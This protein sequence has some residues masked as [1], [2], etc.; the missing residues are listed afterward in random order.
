MAAEPTVSPLMQFPIVPYALIILVFYFLVFKP[1]KDKQKQ[2]KKM[3]ADLKKNDQVV[4]SGGLF[5][6]VVNVRPESITLR[7][8]ENVRVEVESAAIAR[9][10]KPKGQAGE[11]VSAERRG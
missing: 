4:T 5:G 7:I 10:V 3:L 9:L 1:Q 6:T 11:A 8:D 2:T